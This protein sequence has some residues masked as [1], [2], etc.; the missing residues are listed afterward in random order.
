MGFL[1]LSFLFM[2]LSFLVVSLMCSFGSVARRVFDI[3][4]W[5]CVERRD[6][7]SVLVLLF[8]IV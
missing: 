1:I 4:M 6:L 3:F 5:C 2:F 8:L 7:L